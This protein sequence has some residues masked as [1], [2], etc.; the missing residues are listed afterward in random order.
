MGW[1]PQQLFSPRPMLSPTPTP[2]SGAHVVTH[3]LPRLWLFLC[4]GTGGVGRLPATEA[5]GQVGRRL[6]LA[7]LEPLDGPVNRAQRVRRGTG[8]A[9]G[10]WVCGEIPGSADRRGQ[11]SPSPVAVYSRDPDPSPPAARHIVI[12]IISLITGRQDGQHPAVHSVPGLTAPLLTWRRAPWMDRAGVEAGVSSLACFPWG[13]TSPRPLRWGT[14]LSLTS[15]T[16]REG[17]GTPLQYFCLEN[18]MDGGAW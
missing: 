13:G 18:P 15:V 9:Q 12:H 8:E 16:S 3:L 17:N 4:L 10:R 6:N 11:G 2:M 1:H 7:E 5:S 14:E